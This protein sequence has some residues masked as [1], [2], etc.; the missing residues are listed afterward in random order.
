MKRFFLAS[1]AVVCVGL[2]LATAQTI[3]RSVQLSNDSNG[4]IG[5]DTNQGVYFP[6]HVNN[7]GGVPT[8]SSFGT[9]PTTTGSDTG[10]E[11][12]LGTSPGATGTMTF[13]QAFNATPYCTAS[14]SIATA[15]GVV[16]TPNGVTMLH[17]LT[18]GAKIYY[19]CFGGNSG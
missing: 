12:I 7:K 9:S 14:A 1:L 4:L 10:G 13:R 11:I 8:F 2:A 18:S 6:R 19:N 5:F 17:S 16:P 3:N 15:V